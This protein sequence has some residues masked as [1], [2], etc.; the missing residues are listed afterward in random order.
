MS[1]PQPIKN[2]LPITTLPAASA[3]AIALNT[4]RRS[5]LREFNCVSQATSNYISRTELACLNIPTASHNS[6]PPASAR[7]R[8]SCHT[9]ENTKPGARATIHFESCDLLLSTQLNL[10]VQYA[11][12]RLLTGGA[13]LFMV[14]FRFS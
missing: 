2:E 10:D 13:F 14:V 5:T 11:S 4:R 3:L 6:G 12:R 9:G 1:H 8:D 7:D